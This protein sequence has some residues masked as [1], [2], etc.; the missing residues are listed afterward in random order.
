[1]EQ[2]VEL[3]REASDAQRIMT[4]HIRDGWK[5]HT[6]AMSTYTV[7]YGHKTE[8]LVIYEREK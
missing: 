4:Q 1:M 6:C 2:K 5:V 7:G 3:Y 8:V